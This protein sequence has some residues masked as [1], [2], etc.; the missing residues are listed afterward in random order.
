MINGH[1]YWRRTSSP[2]ATPTAAARSTPASSGRIGPADAKL[3]A[4]QAPTY[5]TAA[6]CSAPAPR[7]RSSGAPTTTATAPAPALS[8]S[9]SVTHAGQPVT[10]DASASQGAN[11]AYSWSFGDGHTASGAVVSHAFSSAGSFTVTLTVQDSQTE[12]AATQQQTEVVHPEPVATF[13]VTPQPGERRRQSRSTPAPRRA[14][15]HSRATAGR[16]ATARRR[17][18]AA[19]CTPTPRR[20]ATRSH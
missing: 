6:R 3:P 17:A 20:A 19:P 9:A 8:V 2:T 12:Y 13:E 18:A 5:A 16:S 7:T 4:A 14:P 15:R 1:D 10:F 11:L